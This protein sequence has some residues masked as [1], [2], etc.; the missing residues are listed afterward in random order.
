MVGAGTSIGANVEE[1]QAAHSKLD[2]MVL[3]RF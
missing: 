1:A 2:F 3:S